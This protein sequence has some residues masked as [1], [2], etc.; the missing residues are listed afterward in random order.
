M[1]RQINTQREEF[2]KLG[3]SIGVDSGPGGLPHPWFWVGEPSTASTALAF[4]CQYS[5]F[6]APEYDK[7]RYTHDES[8]P[9][10]SPSGNSNILL[11]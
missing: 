1:S 2:T 5:A 6:S 11:L 9:S 10:N 3:M 8:T 4:A 7:W